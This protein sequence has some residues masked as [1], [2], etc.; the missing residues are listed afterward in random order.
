MQSWAVDVHSP[1]QNGEWKSCSMQKGVF[2][3]TTNCTKVRRMVRVSLYHSH[4]SILLRVNRWSHD[5][6]PNVAIQ[7]N[8]A[9]LQGVRDSRLG[10]PMVTRALAIVHTCI[11]DA[12]AAYDKHPV[13]TQLGDSAALLPAAPSRFAKEFECLG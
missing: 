8:N 9:V 1:R 2:S 5:I 7:C 12:W 3:E 11:Y 10:P 4:L 6:R 13:G